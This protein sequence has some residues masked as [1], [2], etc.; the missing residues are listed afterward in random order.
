M[1]DS[2]LSESI[3]YVNVCP[4]EQQEPECLPKVT[5]PAW[6]SVSRAQPNLKDKTRMISQKT[7]E[8]SNGLELT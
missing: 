4:G 7:F 2:Q 3:V 6:G 5:R 8:E 1:F